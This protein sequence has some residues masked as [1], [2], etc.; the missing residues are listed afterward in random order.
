[1]TRR[2]FIPTAAALPLAA[3]TPSAPVAKFKQA[4]CMEGD[5]IRTIQ[6]NHQWIAHYHTAGIPGRHELNDHRR[7]R[8]HRLHR[9]RILPLGD[10][11]AGLKQAI[12]AFN[13]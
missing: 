2:L 4:V 6:N 10:P 1:M 12:A 7:N 11:E 8:L 13:W 9:P 3:Q 5:V